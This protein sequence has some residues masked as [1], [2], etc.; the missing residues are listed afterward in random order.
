MK[1]KRMNFTIGIVICLISCT[2]PED[3]VIPIENAEILTSKTLII[4]QQIGNQI[5][6]RAVIIDA[7]TRTDSTKK[8]PLVFAFHG[9]GGMNKQ[10][11][12]TLRR[13]TDNG[14]FI[15]VYPQGYLNS[16][17]L[18]AEPSTADDI[19]FVNAIVS[20]L[21]SYTNIDSRKIY[22]IGTSNGSGMVNKL[23]AN[24]THFKAVAA[25]ASQLITSIDITNQTSPVSIFQINGAQ[26]DVIP[27][28]GG[29]RLG[30]TF[31]DA[32]ASAKK[33][34]IQFG[35]NTQPE[36]TS[37]NGNTAYTF[38]GCSNDVLVKYLRVE[39]A[40]HNIPQSY[41]QLWDT[42][43]DFFSEL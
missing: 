37:S 22:A 31:Y 1:I 20:A 34:A 3:T 35:C 40:G 2:Q 24:T 38:S 17:N 43:W 33:W 7:S 9:R 39:N 42:I 29:D 18:G 8:Y 15:G 10:W 5:I 19:A 13:F 16:W 28:G 32:Y 27:I 36:Q 21:S 30:H 14:D 4:E 26:D 11:Q 25:V 23:A 6:S 41:P 12:N